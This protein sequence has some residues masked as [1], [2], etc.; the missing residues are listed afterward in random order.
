MKDYKINTPTLL[1]ESLHSL[2]WYI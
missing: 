2:D 1:N